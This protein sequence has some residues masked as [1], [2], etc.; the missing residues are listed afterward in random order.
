MGHGTRAAVLAMAAW[1]VLAGMGPRV[2]PQKGLTYQQ[3]LPQIEHEL[4]PGS[5]RQDVMKFLDARGLVPSAEEP[6][7]IVL[8]LPN[9][10]GRYLT[11]TRV[12]LQF[13][14]ERGQFITTRVRDLE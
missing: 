1:V 14:F 12:Q 10:P 2:R 7:Q 3:L 8:T 6:E 13:W 4:P 9:S 5:T 11:G